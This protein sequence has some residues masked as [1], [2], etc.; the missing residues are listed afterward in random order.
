MGVADLS[1]DAV[2]PNVRSIPYRAG[3]GLDF[4][5]KL[6]EVVVAV[7]VGVRP[8]VLPQVGEGNLLR[9]SQVGPLLIG[10][11]GFEGC[12][13][14]A[15]AVAVAA[16]AGQTTVPDGLRVSQ[17]DGGAVLVGGEIGPAKISVGP[18]RRGVAVEDGARPRYDGGS[19]FWRP[20]RDD[21]VTVASTGKAMAKKNVAA[22]ENIIIFLLL[23]VSRCTCSG[24]GESGDQNHE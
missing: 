18:G 24:P 7:K 13:F 21:F 19:V 20:R 8:G 10:V 4:G 17:E 12:Q 16:A 9:W 15:V 3:R 1:G 11:V 5:R 22:R 6:V 14:L 2:I 23:S